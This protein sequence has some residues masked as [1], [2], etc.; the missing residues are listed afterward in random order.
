MAL[1]RGDINPLNVVDSRR[2]SFI[3]DHFARMTISASTQALID[4]WVYQNLDSRYAIVKNL[5][6]DSNNKL[7]EIQE[8]GV[9]DPKELT[10]LSLSCPY[11][12][13]KL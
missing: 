7:V 2:L 13:R 9:E 8:I 11:L 3:P 12:D 10:M 6:I 1:K 4:A 5:K